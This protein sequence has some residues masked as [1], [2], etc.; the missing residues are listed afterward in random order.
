MK[1]HQLILPVPPLALALALAAC[2]SGPGPDLHG[3][4]GASL[5]AAY[6]GNWVLLRTESDDLAAKMRGPA[7]GRGG[8]QP[9]GGMLG[10]RRGGG[11]TGGRPGVG[12]MGGGFPGGG[13]P[14]EMR[15]AM[16]SM[17]VLSQAP[18][19]MQLLL[20]ADSVT[21][22]EE[23]P[24]T[25]MVSLGL[26]A[27]EEEIHQAQ[28]TFFARAQWTDKGLEINRKV[29]GGGGVKDKMSLD[30]NGRLIVKREIQNPIFGKVE[31]T[32]IYRKQE[33]GS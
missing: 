3:P 16:Q 18:E 5:M 9:G 32:L 14:E 4:G 28:A 13:D 20:H 23:E 12:G 11:V 10:G 21:I 27:E 29:D 15:Q 1:T 24:R 30:S 33:P 26:G 6:S 8:L 22:A 19:E 25:I 31:G 7:G 17:Q 2:A